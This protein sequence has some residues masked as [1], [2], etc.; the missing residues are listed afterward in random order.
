MPREA[1]AVERLRLRDCRIGCIRKVFLDPAG[2]LFSIHLPGSDRKDDSFLIVNRR[3]E[4]V[5]IEQE[6]DLEC[7]VADALVAVDEW[8]IRDERE[9]EGDCFFDDRWVEVGSVEALPGLRNCR[10]KEPEIP[11]ANSS[12]GQDSEAFVENQDFAQ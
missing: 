2:E 8:M 11:Y 4:L 7:G 9:S 1:P 6:K 3:V 10:F 5:A 12:A